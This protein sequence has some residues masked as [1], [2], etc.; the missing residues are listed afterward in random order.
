MVNLVS[1]PENL[2]VPTDDGGCSHLAGMKLP[3]IYL[4]ST[5]GQLVDCSGLNQRVVLYCYPMTGRPDVSLPEGWDDIPGARGC[6][7]EA[8]GF[9]DH[10][11]E[12]K[13]LGTE[14]YGL[15]TQ[16]T[17]YQQETVARLHLPYALLSDADYSFTKALKL[18][19]FE[20]DSVVLIKRLTL[21]VMQGV[22]E[23]VF[24]PVFPP[25]KHAAEV[26]TWLR[27]H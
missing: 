13:T 15:S 2:P 4:P 5:S 9:R 25:D 14:I 23:H 3:S 12:V 8:C 1:L 16:K 19:V 11:Q 21:I 27:S 10:Y 7:P 17:A 18:P 24:Y 22:I 6:T 20:V 26:L